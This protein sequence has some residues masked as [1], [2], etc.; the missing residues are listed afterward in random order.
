MKLQVK[1]R[2]VDET[3]HEIE[4]P[5]YFRHEDTVFRFYEADEKSIL[6]EDYDIRADKI[7]Q[8]AQRV[9][10]ATGH[11]HGTWSEAYEKGEQITERE[12]LEALT[13]YEHLS[14]NLCSNLVKQIQ[15]VTV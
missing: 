7:D 14:Q 11:H 3:I 9:C 5:C 13:R 2:T 1:K 15:Q 12:F 10:I 8:S 6:G 4:L